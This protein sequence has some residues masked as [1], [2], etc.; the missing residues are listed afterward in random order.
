MPL[1]RLPHS[2]TYYVEEG[3]GTPLVLIHGMG[4]D[5]TV[6]D[7]QVPELRDRFRIIRPDILGHGSSEKP[8]GPWKFTQFA[9]QI[10]ELLDR[11]SIPRTVV[12]GFSLGGSIGQSVAIEYPD[13]IAALIVVSSSCARTPQEQES[14]EKRVAQVAAGGPHAVVD[15]ALGRWF[16]E[17]FRK[18]NPALI[19]YWRTRLLANDPKP[20]L[21]AY[22]LYSD[23]DRQ[24]LHRLGEIRTPTLVITGD[25]DPGQTPRMAEE[26]GRRIAGSELQI[27]PG[28]PHMSTLE[29]APAL[30]KAIAEFAQRRA[31]KV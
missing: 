22:Q 27:F 21:A 2:E 11:L 14:V 29:A 12:A 17:K 1:V 7:W 30:N 4:G 18:E 28:I 23:I 19:E 9:Q 15:G 24:L 31:G 25:N 6:W 8:A 13:R 10:A 20:Y 5:H 3:S 16:T 26:M